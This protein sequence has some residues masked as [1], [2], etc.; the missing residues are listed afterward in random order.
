MPL[1]DDFRLYLNGEE[2]AS[3]KET[4]DKA[5]EFNI[6]DLPDKRVK[7]L[8]ESSG[9]AWQRKK[10][11]LFSTTFPSGV[12]G[13]VVV[14]ASSSP[15]LMGKSS[16]LSRSHGF[17]V[18]V[19][20]RLIN[21]EDALFGIPAKS[22]Q[23]YSRFRAELA[24]DDLDQVLTAPREGIEASTL[25]SRF[26]GLLE[27][28]FN[29]ARVRY[30]AYLEKADNTGKTKKEADRDFVSSRLVEHPV[31]DVLSSAGR[32]ARGAEA[33]ES[34]FYLDVDQS[35]DVKQ[36]INEL[37]NQPRTKYKYEYVKRGKTSRL[38]RFSPRTFTFELNEDHDLVRAYDDDAR[39]RLLLHDISTAEALLEVYL[40]ESQVSS[41]I[42]GE[43]LERRDVL[44]RSLAQDHPYSLKAVADALRDA[45]SDQY[46]L[47]IHLVAAAR[48]LGFV[49]K[50][51]SGGGQPDGIARFTDYPAGE[52]KIT[53]EAKSSQETPALFALDIAGLQ[54]HMN[55][56][57]HAADGCLVIAPSYPGASRKTNS[58]ISKRAIAAKVSCWTI[59]QLARVVEAAESRH[60]NARHV[61]DIVLKRFSPEEVSAAIDDLFALSQWDMRELY[62][63]ILSALRDLEGR[64]LDSPRNLGMISA[65][66]SRKPEFPGIRT[67]DIEKAVSALAASSQG[68]L[69]FTGDQII[70]HV[71]TDEIERRLTGLTKQSAKPMRAS[72]F[73]DAR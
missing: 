71:S 27:E 15:S 38:V 56:K 26:Q 22:F 20:G 47:E 70:L 16:D 46:D 54:E 35:T 65:E 48:A 61:L 51:I 1:R 67:G 64:T 68:G 55:D 9:E 2:I 62:R 3:S 17:F 19:R 50:H 60:L 49:A 72:R 63:V 5:I 24:A 52:K 66:V 30:E 37:Y 45:A 13:N 23:T 28:I 32:D 18:K 42:I 11:G 8:K 57:A 36:L 69:T 58:A 53:L 6:K 44:L 59:E 40:R 12:F 4:Y 34:W 33:D 21:E 41:H 29:E 25:R 31:A 39:A 73:K 7:S 43:V 10:G 14:I